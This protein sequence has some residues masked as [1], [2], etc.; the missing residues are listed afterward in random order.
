MEMWDA[1]NGA[2]LELNR[3][4]AA[5]MNREEFVRFLE[6]VKSVSLAFDGSAYRTMLRNDAYWFTRLGLAIERADNTARIL[7]VKYHLLLPETERVGGSLDYFQWTTVLREVSALTAYHWVYRQSVKPWLVADLLILNRQMPRSLAN[8]CE[9]LVRHLDLIGD[10]YGRRGQSQ[11][12][13]RNMQARLS[14]TNIDNI[15]QSGLHEFITGFVIDNNR[16]G[17]AIAEQYLY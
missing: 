14:S 16:L 7:D 10:A 9:L 8:C 5:R 15:F 6:W 2:W 3:F 12:L 13:A 11:R 1:I 17:N 4:D